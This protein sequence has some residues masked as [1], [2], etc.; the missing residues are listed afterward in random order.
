MPLIFGAQAVALRA[1][2]ITVSHDPLPLLWNDDEHSLENMVR[3]LQAD[4]GADGGTVLAVGD[5]VSRL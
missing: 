2:R 1:Q 3:R 4:I 5:V